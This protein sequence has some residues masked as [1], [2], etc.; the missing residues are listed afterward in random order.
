MPSEKTQEATETELYLDNISIETV[1]IMYRITVEYNGKSN[2][3]AYVEVGIGTPPQKLKFKIDN[4]A[5]A[6]PFPP[7]CF[8]QCSGNCH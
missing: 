5:Q 4:E 2:Q 1:S 7:T 3:Q 8:R 6:T